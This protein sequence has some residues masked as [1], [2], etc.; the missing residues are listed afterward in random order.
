MH[1]YAEEKR[2]ATHGT[3]IVWNISRWPFYHHCYFAVKQVANDMKSM[4]YS[5]HVFNLLCMDDLRLIGEKWDKVPKELQ[6]V[7][8]SVT[9]IWNWVL[10]SVKR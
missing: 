1:L 6:T 2:I 9:S 4:C 5:Y 7:K 8:T 3:G 10:T